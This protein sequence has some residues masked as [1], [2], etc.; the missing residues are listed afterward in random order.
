MKLLSIGNSFSQDAQRW[1]HEI[2]ACGNENIDTYNLFI[3]GCSLATH[4]DCICGRKADYSLEGNENRQIRTVTANEI[5]ENE[6][7]DVITLQQASGFSGR[8]QSYVPYLT[9]L[10]EYVR[11][12]Q[13]QAKLLFHE[14]WSYE[15]DSTHGHFAFYRHDQGEMFRRI[16]DCAETAK[17]LIGVDMIPAGAFIQYL[18]ENTKDFCYPEGG[19]S[20]CRDGFHLS[21]DYGRFAAAAI[22]YK[23]LTGKTPAVASF[24]EK[25]PE[26][27]PRLLETV[28]TAMRDFYDAPAA[29]ER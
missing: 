29:E 2:A 13:P 26:F 7:F 9:E 27:D 14:T 25:H 11:R 24:A 6:A 18:R 19:L 4:M 10:A 21:L 20:L 23:E 28:V 1:L 12:H 17:R 22:W 16:A 3:G 5:I 8:P 15:T